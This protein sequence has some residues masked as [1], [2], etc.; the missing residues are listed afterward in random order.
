VYCPFVY[1]DINPTATCV[2][3]SVSENSAGNPSEFGKELV[4]ATKRSVFSIAESREGLC[5]A[6]RNVVFHLHY[7]SV[8][9]VLKNTDISTT[10]AAVELALT[11]GWRRLLFAV[12]GGG[13][14]KVM[15][16]AFLGLGLLLAVSAAQAQEPRVKAN[17]PFD[18]VVGDRV[19]PAGEYQVSEMGA[20]GHAIA[21]LS[22]DRKA[23]A[24]VVTS[25]CATS[26]PSKSSK[27][28]FHAIG[29]RYFLSQVW[30]EGYSQGRQLQESKAEIELAKNG[31]TSKDLVLAAN[32]SH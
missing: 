12:F 22:E 8:S 26:G 30:T 31:T 11:R 19:M 10:K 27:L 7:L 3:L 9:V 13:S 21:I 23:N 20:S 4:F 25:A 15:R 6:H 18:F 24:L 1:R 17:I 2:N 29:G 16:S 14:M 28:V 5:L 32:R